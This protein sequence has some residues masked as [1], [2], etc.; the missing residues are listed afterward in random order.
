MK[1]IKAK[2]EH[3]K[4]ISTLM[5][6]DLKDPNPKFPSEMIDNFREH[7]KEENISNEFENPKLMAFV[8]VN[9]KFLEFIVGYENP[10]GDSAMIHYITA[11]KTE[12]KKALLDQFIKECNSK[13]MKKIITESFEFMS[14]NDFFKSNKFILTKKE[15]ITPNLEML[16]YE[17]NLS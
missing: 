1:I 13:C 7:A 9:E 14:N 15:E 8:A 3:A 2:I 17:L 4:R 10:S 12:T 5:L 16:W 11:D 6:S